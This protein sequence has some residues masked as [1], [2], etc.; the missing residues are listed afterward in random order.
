M[1]FVYG[2]VNHKQPQI[3]EL[4]LNKSLVKVKEIIEEGKKLGE[5]LGNIDSNSMTLYVV[6]TIEGAVALWIMNPEIDIQML[7]RNNYNC[8]WRSISKSDKYNEE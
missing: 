7:F 3:F 5:F 8:V 4:T 2:K 1:Y 6:S